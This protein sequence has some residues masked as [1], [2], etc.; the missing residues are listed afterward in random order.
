MITLPPFV[1]MATIPF[2]PARHQPDHV[3]G[4]AAGADL[5]AEEPVLNNFEAGPAA[6]AAD[7]KA[8]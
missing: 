7:D 8:P 1:A 5:P 6:L 4:K 3:V 2:I